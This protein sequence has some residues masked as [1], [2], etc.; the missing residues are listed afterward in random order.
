MIV[1]LVRLSLRPDAVDAFHALFAES[2]ATIRQFPGCLRLELLEDIDA[3]AVR[4]TYSLW[5][6]AEALEAYRQSAYFKAV[7]RQTKPLFA[8]PAVAHSYRTLLTV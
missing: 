4:T 2:S 7:W 3:P 6:S 5:E 8:S 1:R